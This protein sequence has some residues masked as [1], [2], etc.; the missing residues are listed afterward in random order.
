MTEEPVST[1]QIRKYEDLIDKKIKVIYFWCV[2]GLAESGDE[3]GV[4]KGNCFSTW[5]IR[6]FA[7]EY[8]TYEDK[9]LK[10]LVNIGSEVYAQA[11]APERKHIFVNIGLG[12][13]VEFTLDEALVYIEKKIKKLVMSPWTATHR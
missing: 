3:N 13:H 6:Y 2:W 7:N 9:E 8:I 4:I 12:F 5:A 1:A 10:S 11:K